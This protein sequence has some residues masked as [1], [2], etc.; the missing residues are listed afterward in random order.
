MDDA[1]YPMSAI[2]D[3]G[4]SIETKKKLLVPMGL[5]KDIYTVLGTQVAGERPNTIQEDSSVAI[6]LRT[7]ARLYPESVLYGTST[8]RAIVVSQSGY[9]HNPAYS[10]TLPQTIDLAH[11]VA[12]YMGAG[13]GI[14]KVGE[15]FDIA[16]QN[17]VTQ[18]RDLSNTYKK[19]RV[20]NRD[21]AN[22]M[23]WSQSYNR[24]SFFYPAIQTVYDDDTSILNSAINMM[25]AVELEKVCQRV[26]RDLTGNSTLTNEQFIEHS[27]T[28]IR[29]ATDKRFDD[30]VTIVPETFLTPDDSARGYSWSCNINM[31]GNNM[32]SV[33]SF[34]VVARRSE[35]LE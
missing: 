29:Q 5:R 15:G 35:D 19:D 33:G 11:K 28:L 21:W 13:N 10:K 2:W 4:F 26:W 20:R 8:C 7:A 3:S 9:L 16:G 25:I 18:L 17:H 22:G 1:V 12:S 34:T 27:N 24:R 30:R 23:V 14:Y 6:A 32:K 31:Y